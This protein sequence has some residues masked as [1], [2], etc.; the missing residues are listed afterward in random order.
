MGEGRSEK[1]WVREKVNAT[2]VGMDENEKETAGESGRDNEVNENENTM[3]GG[4]VA[5]VNGKQK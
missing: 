4:V 2:A 5:R 3:A 1:E